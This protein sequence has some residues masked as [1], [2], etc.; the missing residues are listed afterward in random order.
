MVLDSKGYEAVTKGKKVDSKDISCTDG[1]CTLFLGNKCPSLTQDLKCSIHDNPDRPQAC[2]DFPVFTLGNK[3]V[4]SGRC[5]AVK[6]NKFYPFVSEW[7]KKGNNVVI[8]NSDEGYDL[9]T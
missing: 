3:V 9:H 6:Q 2:K 4:L 5:L 1:K 7:I 8:S